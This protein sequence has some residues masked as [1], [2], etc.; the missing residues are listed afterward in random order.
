MN[1]ERQW[2]MS[3]ILYILA[4]IYNQKH[5]ENSKIGLENSFFFFQK[6]G[7]PALVPC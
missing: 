5:L 4:A 1:G 2:W 3:R 7:N 6:S